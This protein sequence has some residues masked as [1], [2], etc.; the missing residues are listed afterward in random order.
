[1]SLYKAVTG[2][3]ELTADDIELKTLD[4]TYDN[5]KK[6]DVAFLCKNHI[7]QV[8]NQNLESQNHSQKLLALKIL[9]IH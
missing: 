3:N 5:G 2:D 6:N 9:C 1:M 4:S 7:M 8:G